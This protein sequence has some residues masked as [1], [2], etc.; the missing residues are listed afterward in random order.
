MSGTHGRCLTVSRRIVRDQKRVKRLL[1][2]PA[3]MITG[4]QNTTTGEV[5]WRNHYFFNVIENGFRAASDDQIRTLLANKPFW[6]DYA[7]SIRKFNMRRWNDGD[8]F[9]VNYTGHPMQGA[10]SG[11]FRCQRMIRKAG[12]WRSVR[13]TNTGRAG[14]R[15]FYGRPLQYPLRDQPHRRS[16]H[17]QRGWLDLPHPL[18][19]SLHR[20]RHL[21]TLHEQHWM[22]RFHRHPDGWNF[23]VA[24]GR[25][26][27][28]HISATASRAMTVPGSCQKLYGALEPKQDHGER[29]TF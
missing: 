6:H 5:C 4:H 10:V 24:R 19:D 25:H 17:W 27:G 8:D 29:G 1:S 2:M 28:S 23:M 11:L 18:Q 15:H 20:T 26:V 3:S 22:G 14:S 21:Q 16:R 9:L 13:T 7:A 12:S